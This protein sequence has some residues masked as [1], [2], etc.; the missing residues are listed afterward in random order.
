MS[1]HPD[2]QQIAR[3]KAIIRQYL[4][5]EEI[6]LLHEKSDL[7][8]ALEVAK[9]W[10]WIFIAFAV[11]YVY[12]HPLTVVLSM[13]ILAGKQL[14]C[15]IIMHDTSHQSLFKSAKL[16]HYMGNWL[17]AYPIFQNLE[18]YRPYHLQH[19]VATGTENDPDIL[20]TRGYPTSKSSLARKFFRDLIGITG[21]KAL[22]GVML[23]HLGFL[24]Y[25]LG[26]K[27]E[28][29]NPEDQ[30]LRK[31][32]FNFWHHLK[33]PIAFHVLFFMLFY[34][35]GRPYLYVLWWA[36]YLTTYNF[37]LRVRSIAEHS[38][39]KDSTDPL[40]NTRTTYANF[41]ERMLFAPLHV[42]YHLEH[43]LLIAAPCYQYPKLHSML[44]E[45]GFYATALLEPGYLSVMR[46][47][48]RTKDAAL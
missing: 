33:G 15:A 47:T 25:N 17:G 23:M 44:K 41:L 42:N 29:T 11:V 6:R 32:L 34:L 43:H 38:L 3:Y 26:N 19:H 20:L 14:G 5:K 7:K 46:K 16:N 2:Q 13:F 9:V 1:A 30:S 28:R 36:S 27:V 10:I 35:L 18:Q 21:I 8:G 37:V 45:R 4:S 48:I 31:I 12:P 39:V 24:R 22:L 40:R